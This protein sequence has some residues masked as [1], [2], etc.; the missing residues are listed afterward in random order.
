VKDECF[1]LR[2]KEVRSKVF[3]FPKKV[4]S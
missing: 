3:S 2:N 4:Q 1:T